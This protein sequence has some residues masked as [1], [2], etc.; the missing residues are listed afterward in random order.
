MPSLPVLG[1]SGTALVGQGGQHAATRAAWAQQGLDAQ[2]RNAWHRLLTVDP[3]VSHLL[4]SPHPWLWPQLLFCAVTSVPRANFILQGTL[5]C[6][7]FL[8]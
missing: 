1:A 6:H 5:L 8:C 2:S 7:S 3:T 4:C